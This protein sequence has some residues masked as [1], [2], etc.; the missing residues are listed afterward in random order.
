M[1]DRTMRCF[2]GMPL[3]DELRDNLSEALITSEKPRNIRRINESLWHLTLVFLGEVDPENIKH[4]IR[5]CKYYKRNFGT[6]TINRLEAF[7]ALLSKPKVIAANG[8]L[9]PTDKWRRNVRKMRTELLPYAPNLD[10]KKWNAHIALAR[11]KT[12]QD[13]LPKWRMPIGPWTWKP[14]GFELIQ[15]R[16][17]EHGPIHR[18][19]HEFP[20]AN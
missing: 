8:L 6:F 19:I 14:G 10:T 18:T 11:P 17:T 1:N 4:I 16:L 7:P 12:K 20:F 13:M 3:A 9:Q 15:S 5:I 2:I